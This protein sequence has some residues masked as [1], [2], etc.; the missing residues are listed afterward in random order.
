MEKKLVGAEDVLDKYHAGSDLKGA[1]LAEPVVITTKRVLFSFY[2]HA[3]L[4]KNEHKCGAQEGHD[5]LAERAAR[6]GV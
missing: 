4:C 6:G 5:A 1:L 3:K 2:A